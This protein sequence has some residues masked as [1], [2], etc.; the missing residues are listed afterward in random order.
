M[1][2]RGTLCGLFARLRLAARFAA[3]NRS[4]AGE[5]RFA[6]LRLAARFACLC[7]LA[8]ALG[9]ACQQRQTRPAASAKATLSRPT[10]PARSARFH[11]S[12]GPS[13]TAISSGIISGTK[14]K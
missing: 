10:T 1:R 11:D 6:R 9:L 13:D 7:G 5:D 2:D 8:A 12:D 3:P 4:S 14:V